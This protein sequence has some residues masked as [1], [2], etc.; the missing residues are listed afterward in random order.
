[1]SL[2]PS[3][4]ANSTCSRGHPHPGTCVEPLAPHPPGRGSRTT[5]LRVGP[6][7]PRD[8]GVQVAPPGTHLARHRR[9]HEQHQKEQQQQSGRPRRRPGAHRGRRLTGP[10]CPGTHRLSG[11][12]VHCAARVGASGCEAHLASRPGG[13]FC[14]ARPRCPSL[15]TE[16]VDCGAVGREGVAQVPPS[17][18]LPS[19]SPG[20][21]PPTRASCPGVEK[22]LS[23]CGAGGRGS[24]AKGLKR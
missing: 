6:A 18:P 10:A 4:P 14:R 9:G 13:G 3:S 5:P 12:R 24:E 17:S 23:A 2:P 21:V 16:A 19:N 20:T 8:A 7:C 1:M 22:G 11:Y 15:P